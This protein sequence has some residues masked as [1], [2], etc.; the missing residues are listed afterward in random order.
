MLIYAPSNLENNLLRWRCHTCMK[1][2]VIGAQLENVLEPWQHDL[3]LPFFRYHWDSCMRLT[4]S[5]NKNIRKETREIL[6]PRI[7]ILQS[8]GKYPIYGNGGGP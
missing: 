6:V 4:V 2:T 8:I 3:F 7:R 5:S 1:D